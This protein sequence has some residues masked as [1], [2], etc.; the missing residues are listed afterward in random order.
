LTK[1]I[2]IVPFVVK[3]LPGGGAS[4]SLSRLVSALAQSSTIVHSCAMLGTKRDIASRCIRRLQSKRFMFFD[5]S[6]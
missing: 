4:R 6:Q 3:N 1:N 2:I 5:K